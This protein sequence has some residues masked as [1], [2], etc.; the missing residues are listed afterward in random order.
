M[1][2]RRFLQNLAV[3]T[4]ALRYL[5]QT[6]DA[7]ERSDG[8]AQPIGSNEPELAPDVEGHSLLCEF[9]I[10]STTW[11]VFEDLRARDGAI[12]FLSSRGAS[13]V[14]P[15]TAEATFAEANPPYLGLS[16]KDIAMSGPDLLAD[17]LLQNGDPDPN[18]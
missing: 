15:K 7:A 2:R 10:D 17:K 3:T 8:F 13:R 12:T 16:L 4:A 5:P 1:D 6:A 11:K 9:K 18:Q 14:L